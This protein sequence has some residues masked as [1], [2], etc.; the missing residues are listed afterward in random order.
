[1]SSDSVSPPR[2]CE[3][4]LRW[5]LERV[6]PSIRTTRTSGPRPMGRVWHDAVG[7]DVQVFHASPIPLYAQIAEQLEAAIRTGKLAKGNRIMSEAAWAAAL[8]VSI[9]TVH[10]AIEELIKRRLLRSCRGHGTYVDW[11]V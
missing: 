5:I 2:T 1:M 6:R 3:F 10:R 7:T 4:W 9:P 11:L 8:Q